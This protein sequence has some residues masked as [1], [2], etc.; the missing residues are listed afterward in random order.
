M[1]WSNTFNFWLFTALSFV[2]GMLLRASG[3]QPSPDWLAWLITTTIVVGFC[4]TWWFS[5]CLL[6]AA[7]V[8][9]T[10]IFLGYHEVLGVYL[11]FTS[12]LV[13]LLKKPTPPPA[14]RLPSM[15]PRD[16]PLRH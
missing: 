11:V 7:T 3:E 9:I 8:T 16:P 2:A 13:I 4:L 10:S 1:T 14:P 15:A 12:V 5:R 6:R